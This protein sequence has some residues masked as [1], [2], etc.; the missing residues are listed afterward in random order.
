MT[1]NPI[2]RIVLSVLAA[3]A[4]R[5]T[6]AYAQGSCGVMGSAEKT[7]LVDYVQK[8]YKTPPSVHLQIAEVSLVKGSCFRKL[9]FTAQEPQASFR[10]DLFASP[11]LRFLAREVMDSN[12]DPIAE[13]KQR[14]E[15]LYAGLTHGDFPTRGKTNAPVTLAVFSDFQCPYCSRFAAIVTDLAPE[16]AAK[17]RLVFRHL[18]LPMH[19]W[20]RPAAEATACAQEQGDSYFWGLHDF[21]FDHQK[22]ITRDNILQKLA[23]A[24]KS[25]SG[26]DQGKFAA[27]VIERKT[28]AQVERDISFAQ[29]HGINATPTVFLNGQQT[30][31]VAA[32]QLQTLLREIGGAPN[33]QG[34]S[35]ASA[36]SPRNER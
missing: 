16:E 22:E 10:L 3:A 20:A 35:S 32:E 33:S 29:E 17:V 13:E 6:S 5:S 12:G 1:T 23:E 30:Q 11:D 26:F 18:P 19:S 27:C 25:V 36:G 28:A 8:K 34:G 14:A 24:E 7:R 15:A 4:I 31:I 21:L 2:V 9:E